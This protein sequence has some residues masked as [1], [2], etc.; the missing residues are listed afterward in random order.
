MR[1]LLRLLREAIDALRENTKALRENAEASRLLAA[2]IR[3]QSPMPQPAR[4]A[5]KNTPAA[6]WHDRIVDRLWKRLRSGE[7]PESFRD[8]ARAVGVPRS[9][10]DRSSPASDDPADWTPTERAW[11]AAREEYERTLDGIA[12]AAGPVG[13]AA[14]DWHYDAAKGQVVIR[15]DA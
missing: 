14:R 11:V 4:P 15:A 6:E 13:P 1:S 8:A 3:D 12:A 10:L 7:P 2:A 9:T 5:G